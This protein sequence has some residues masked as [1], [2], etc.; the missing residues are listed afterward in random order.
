MHHMF[1]IW[2]AMVVVMV[3]TLAVVGSVSGESAGCTSRYA[4]RLSQRGI[5]MPY[6]SSYFAKPVGENPPQQVHL[7]Q[8][9]YDGKA[10]IVSFVTS[11]LAMP[12]VRYGTVRGKY[13]S[14]VTGYTTQY[15]FHNYTSGFI[16][17]VVI[18][19]LEF[20]TKYFYKVG[21]EEEGAREF[22]FTTPP[23]PGPDTP[24]AF[25][26]IGDLGQTFDSA[27]TVEHYLKSYGQT[28]L[29]VGDL[30]Y[31]D[32]Y[33]FHYQVRFD[34]WSRFVERS[35]AYQPWI[36]TTGNHEIDFLPHI[37]EITPF[38]P[39][40]H[41]FP[42]PHDASSSSS[43][44]WYA[45]K[46]GPVH[47]IVLSSYS[48]YGKYTPQYSWLVAELKKV[49]RKVTPWLIVLVHSPWYN[50]N[51]HH[52]IEAETM[53]VI[54]EPFIVA[55]KVD[56]V[57]AGHVHAYERT[58]PVSNIKYNITNGACIPE[59]NPASPTYITVGDGGNIE[60]LAIGFSEPQ[61]H[62]SAFR[63]S[64]FGFGLLDIKN[65]TTATWTWHRNQDGEAV[66]ADS[67]ILHNKIYVEK[68]V[69]LW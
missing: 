46:R 21:E 18:S 64:S 30:A 56:I 34:T 24:Y 26:V 1:R 58:F 6:N 4:R 66:S 13:P 17:H 51:T 19:D 45:I 49:D 29:F 8:G 15:T 57:F 50:S 16:H 48:A 37:G 38:K 69:M 53:R 9:D 3:V 2:M 61:P 14:V 63:E 23:A 11:K 41:R 7:T 44:Q 20:N 43:P 31:Q 39:F 62:Y 47:I 10:V 27:T 36:W 42:T 22:F 68:D 59:V 65:R 55:A 35:A 32:T 25:G 33:P 67:V 60:G 54:F 40:N 12:K 5:D 52:Y 28:V